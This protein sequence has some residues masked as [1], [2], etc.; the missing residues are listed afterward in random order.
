MRKSRSRYLIRR[1]GAKLAPRNE[2]W[3]DPESNWGHKAFQASALPAELSRQ[4]FVQILQAWLLV[5]QISMRHSHS[6]VAGGL[7]LIS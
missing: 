2:W 4:R 1:K 5:K 6:M 3:Q 7:E